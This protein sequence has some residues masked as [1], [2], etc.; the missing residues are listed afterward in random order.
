[1]SCTKIKPRHRVNK[2]FSAPPRRLDRHNKRKW[3][4]SCF[5]KK[6]KRNTNKISYFVQCIVK[7]TY[8]LD[9]EDWLG[10]CSSSRLPGSSK[11]S[12]TLKQPTK[13]KERK[14]NDSEIEPFESDIKRTFIKDRS[15]FPSVLDHASVSSFWRHE[16]WNWY[17]SLNR[18]EAWHS[19]QNSNMLTKLMN[20]Y[21]SSHMQICH[22]ASTI[23]EIGRPALTVRETTMYLEAFHVGVLLSLVWNILKAFSC[24]VI[25]F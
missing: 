5:T 7:V 4:K 1:M 23:S 13:K 6:W 22:R 12:N 9:N 20:I 16:I 3:V 18:R 14:Q 11:Q 25:K 15:N 17:H 21:A 24:Y 8:V 2:N 19:H 10:G